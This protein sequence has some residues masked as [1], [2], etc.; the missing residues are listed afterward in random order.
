MSRTAGLQSGRA[1][2]G[3]ELRA[4]VH[5]DEKEA[6]LQMLQEALEK[7]Q[8]QNID[9]QKKEKAAKSHHQMLSSELDQLVQQREALD[10]S[11]AATTLQCTQLNDSLRIT[12]TQFQDRESANRDHERRLQT[13][14]DE[15]REN[16]LFELNTL[17]KEHAAALPEQQ[18]K[19]ESQNRDLVAA[20][21]EE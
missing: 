6:E 19:F 5:A 10:E 14:I 11:I 7:A 20:A 9:N 13:L 21:K 12:E 3:G 2:A 17:R 15:K 16:Q 18:E 1:E 4:V 8:Q